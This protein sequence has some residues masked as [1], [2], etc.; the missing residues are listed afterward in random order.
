MDFI[1]SQSIKI[2]LQEDQG[3]QLCTPDA[4]RKACTRPDILAFD[5][6]SQGHIIG[7]AQLCR[8]DEG[9]W[10]LWNYAMDS[11]WQG[12]GLGKAA[13]SELIALMKAR[14]GLRRMVTTYLFGN[15]PAKHLY[16]SVGFVETDVVDEPDCHE[17]NMALN[18][19]AL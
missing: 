10:F 1:P 5:I 17:V 12:Q 2:H 6:L 14:H 16:E 7:F 13:L 4:I 18:V 15:A 11:A 3:R 19:E 9:T 8:F